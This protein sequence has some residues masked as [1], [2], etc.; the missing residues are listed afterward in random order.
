MPSKRVL[1]VVGRNLVIKTKSDRKTQQFVFDAKT[2]TIKS[3]ANK[4][5]SFNIDGNGR[6]RNIRMYNTNSNWW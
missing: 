5:W 1:D 3:M 4:G 2:R 6:S